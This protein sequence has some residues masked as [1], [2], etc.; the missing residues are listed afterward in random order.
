[1]VRRRNTN[2]NFPQT[3]FIIGFASV[4]ILVLVSTYFMD[5]NNVEYT[6]PEFGVILDDPE[7]YSGSH[8]PGWHTIKSGRFE[9]QAPKEFKFFRMQGLDSYVGGFTNKQDTFFF[10]YGWYSNN[11]QDFAPPDF[12]VYNKIMNGKHFKVIIGL[13][14]NSYIAAFTNDLKNEKSLIIEC[15]G[16]SHLDEKLI[17]IETIAF[18]KN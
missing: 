16:C 12:E 5:K 18:R 2:S 8:I 13:K 1:M 17:I 11:L 7:Y 14:G 6:T 3:G 9:I 4:L 10:D 15:P